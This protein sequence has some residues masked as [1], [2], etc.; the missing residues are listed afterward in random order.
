MSQPLTFGSSGNT[1]NNPLNFGGGN[2]GSGYQPLTLGSQTPGFQSQQV[3]YQ[4][5]TLGSQPS[6]PVGTLSLGL[7]QESAFAPITNYSSQLM[8]RAQGQWSVA[9]GEDYEQLNRI[10]SVI[11]EATT[12]IIAQRKVI[13]AAIADFYG[14]SMQF[15]K[16][17][18]DHAL[19]ISKQISAGK[20]VSQSQ[21]DHM[22][23]L[24]QLA[25]QIGNRFYETANQLLTIQK[26]NS[27]QKLA[28]FKGV[29]DLIFFS[30]MKELDLLKGRLELCQ[31]Q[32]NFELHLATAI[33]TE[34]LKAEAQAFDQHL[35]TI[36]FQSQERQLE[37]EHD[38]KQR[39]QDHT[40]EVD[41]T[42]LALARMEIIGKQDLEKMAALGQQKISEAKVR[43]EREISEMQIRGQ[44]KIDMQRIKA[45]ERV[46]WGQI[47]TSSL[48]PT[49][50]I[51]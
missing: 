13:D 48:K 28:D 35:K 33:Q 2:S 11:N 45:E 17:C 42:K 41:L 12:S 14:Q 47:I 51:M 36:Q 20:D 50:S 31:N 1:S 39:E 30:R 5:L 26:L 23:F 49:C 3:G 19:S 46:K 6:Q 34:A 40:A 7:G 10:K 9:K 21:I 29:I 24:M 4:P 38:L 43:N 37:F 25:T 32:T 22:N 27:E 44:H 16:I 15:N 18:A 8:Q